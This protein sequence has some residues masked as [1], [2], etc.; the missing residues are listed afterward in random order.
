MALVVSSFLAIGVVWSF[1]PTFE[2]LAER[3]ATDPQYSHGFL[4]PL[5]AAIILWIKKPDHVPWEPNWLGLPALAAIIA[6]RWLAATRDDGFIDAV[7]LVL[8]LL[9]LVLLAGGLDLFR[10]SWPAILF[11]GF[12][13]PL[14][15]VIEETIAM[16]LRRVAT[17]VSTYVLQTLGYPALAEG[18]VILIDDLRLGVIDACSGLGMLMT[19]F[20]LATALAMVVEAPLVDRLILVASAIPIAVLANVIRITLTSM[21][22]Y[23]LGWQEHRQI[24]HDG[25]GWLMMPLALLLLWMELKFLRL[26]LV[27]TDGE[28][29]LQVPLSPWLEK[30][31]K[32][33]PL[34][35]WRR[36]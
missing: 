20:A 15:F 2:F 17:V 3:W 19:F 7:C 26:L 16:P 8:S 35:W 12:M 27:P 32:A 1:W 31:K 22:F 30:R 28:A 23:N 11:L 13:I 25:L 4:V 5:F 21:A 6:L 18:N 34:N 36:S 9:A 29:P 10:W 14:P 24:I 33:G